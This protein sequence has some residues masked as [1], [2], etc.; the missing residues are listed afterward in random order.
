MNKTSSCSNQVAPEEEVLQ[1]G[2]VTPGI[3]LPAIPVDAFSITLILLTNES[4]KRS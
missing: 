2:A 3:C 1:S 4:G